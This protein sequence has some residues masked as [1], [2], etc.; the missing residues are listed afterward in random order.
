MGREEWR[1]AEES[2]GR[3]ERSI[4]RRAGG[5]ESDADAD[6]DDVVVDDAEEG[7]TSEN[8]LVR[9]PRVLAGLCAHS[10]CSAAIGAVGGVPVVVVVVVV[11]RPQLCV[12]V[13]LAGAA[14]AATVALH[15]RSPR[16]LH[17]RSQQSLPQPQ[18]PHQPQGRRLFTLS[19]HALG[20]VPPGVQRYRPFAARR[21]SAISCKCHSMGGAGCSCRVWRCEQPL[22]RVRNP[23]KS[24]AWQPRITMSSR[25]VPTSPETR[26]V[27]SLPTIPRRSLRS[28]K[29]LSEDFKAA[30]MC[31]KVNTRRR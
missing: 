1:A 11:L 30:L 4:L 7:V 15:H 24:S 25:P 10:F 20:L 8:P 2:M 18:T 16:R 27:H 6:A 17:Q 9:E 29:I 31:V 28:I 21:S 13:C 22:R 26:P 23:R 3:E 14:S 19:S 5:A 12:I